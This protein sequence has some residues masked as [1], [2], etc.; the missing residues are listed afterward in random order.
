MLDP[1]VVMPFVTP[2]APLKPPTVLT[3]VA[4]CDPRAC[5][6]HFETPSDTR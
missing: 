6:V 4:V 1:D 2:T 3:P 5:A